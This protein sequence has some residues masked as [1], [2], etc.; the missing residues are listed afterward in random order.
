MTAVWRAVCNRCGEVATDPDPFTATAARD[1]HVWA[2]GHAV[3]S[4]ELVYPDDDEEG[5]SRG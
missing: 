3:T 5:E 2:G 1:A 4:L